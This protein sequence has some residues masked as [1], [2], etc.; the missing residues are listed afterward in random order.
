MWLSTHWIHCI[1]FD[2]FVLFCYLCP[3]FPADAEMSGL[4]VSKPRAL[5]FMFMVFGWKVSG[6]NSLCFEFNCYLCD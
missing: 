3:V 1:G 4:M 6:S 5:Y 2:F